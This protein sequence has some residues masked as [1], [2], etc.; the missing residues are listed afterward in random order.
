MVKN[1]SYPQGR[2]GSSTLGLGEAGLEP[3]AVI[4]ASVPP[5]LLAPLEFGKQLHAYALRHY[6]LIDNSFVEIVK[7]QG[8]KNPNWE[9]RK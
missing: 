7:C 3:D 9:G 4:T 1:S 5:P 2:H 8:S 6:I